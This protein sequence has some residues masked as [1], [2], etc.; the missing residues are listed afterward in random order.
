[1]EGDVCHFQNHSKP[2]SWSYFGNDPGRLVSFKCI[3]TCQAQFTFELELHILV[4]MW[5]SIKNKV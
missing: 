3:S 1:M 5:D 2:V 4:I